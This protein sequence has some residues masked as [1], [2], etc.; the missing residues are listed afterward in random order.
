MDTQPLTL[1]PERRA[2]L[3]AYAELHGQSPAEALDD[4]LAA[5]LEWERRE[6]EDTVQA[7]LR[8]Y[9][10]VKA[11][12]TKPAEEVHEALRRKYGL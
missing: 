11:G 3:E 6:Y 5:Q 8:G 12:R 10:D 1:K 4:L 9:A 7:A 2:E